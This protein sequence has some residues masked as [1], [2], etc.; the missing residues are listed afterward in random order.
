MP[1]VK[2]SITI[3]FRYILILSKVL[4]Y[5]RLKVIGKQGKRIYI[6]GARIEKYSISIS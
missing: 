6:Y 3:I 4:E 2:Y 1:I 5:T